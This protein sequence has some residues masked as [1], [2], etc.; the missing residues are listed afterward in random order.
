MSTQ[1]ARHARHSGDTDFGDAI[2]T[3]IG[4]L[5]IGLLGAVFVIVWWALLFPMISAPIALTIAASVLL[6]TRAGITVAL[7]CSAALTLWKMKWPNSFHRLVSLRARVRF[8]R[9]YRYKRC[10]TRRLTACKLTDGDADALYVPH[11]RSVEI[12]EYIDRVRV[13]ML[14]GQSPEDYH[15]RAVRLAHAFGALECRPVDAGP[16]VV[17]LVFRHG[18]S[19]AD[20]VSMPRKN[21][22]TLPRYP[23]KDV[24]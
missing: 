12:G 21:P 10:W 19:L 1:P 17:E 15:L 11:V 18:D 23:R 3:A 22:D 4:N 9:W 7:A 6:D 16:S 14:E 24:A 5:I 8:L 2:M 20:P 13:R